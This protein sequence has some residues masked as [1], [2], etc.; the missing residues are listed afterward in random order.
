MRRFIDFLLQNP[1]LLLVIGAWV[2][3]LIGNI[4]KAAKKAREQ[5]ERSSRAPEPRRGAPAPTPAT[6]SRPQPAA[7]ERGGVRS[8]EEIAREMRRILGA[9]P[10]S[11]DRTPAEASRGDV[12]VDY[13]EVPVATTPTPPPLPERLRRRN[14]PEPEKAPTPVVPTTS[15]R[16]L[17][18]HV[19]PHVGESIQQRTTVRSGRVGDHA[20]GTELGSL[21]GRTHERHRQRGM[22]GR[23]ALVDLKRIIVLNEILGPPLAL[24]PASDR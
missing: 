21:G 24:R 15:A 13:D 8:A 11:G 1:I 4:L 7:A 5:A 2:F 9:D 16:R 19:D 23:Y 12:G 10:R 3:G 6:R 20:P 17:P 18:I 14:V 22:A